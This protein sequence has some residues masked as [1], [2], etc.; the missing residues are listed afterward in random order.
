MNN[1]LRLGIFM[2]NCSNMPNLSTYKPDPEDWHFSRNL[3]ISRAAEDAGFDFLFPVS[4]WRTFGGE[5]DFLGKS[6]ETTT[7]ASAILFG[8]SRIQIFSTVHVPAFN[9]LVVAKMGA[10]L[11]H[12]GNGRWGINIVS[13]WN[14]AEFDM[15]GIKLEDHSRRYER[16]ADFIQILKG[17]WTEPP[18]SF[19]YDCDWY[20]IRN[21]YINPQPIARPHPPIANAGTSEDARNVVAEHCDWAFISPA[22]LDGCAEIAADFKKRGDTFNRK[23]RCVAAV[24]VLCRKTRKEAEKERE[25]ILENLDSVALG[26][27]LE[28]LGIGSGSFADHTM[29][30]L[31]FGAGAL[32]VIGTPEEVAAQL[33][34][35]HTSGVDGVLM[36]YPDYYN[37]TVSFGKEVVPRLRA[38]GS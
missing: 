22:T 38:L 29:D 13:G 31:A 15:M 35:V 17:L 16:T 28:E 8:T 6:I 19:N 5:C 34:E 32:P 1:H 3:E 4:R 10:S 23:V 24:M 11:D 30:E 37:D 27:Y 7:W 9:P 26:N 2:P 12:I 14:Q 18:G 33:H 25:T 21:G 20:N 36:S